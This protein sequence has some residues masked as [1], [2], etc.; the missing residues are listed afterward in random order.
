MAVNRQPL[1]KNMIKRILLTISFLTWLQTV[2]LCFAGCDY[3]PIGSTSVSQS[4]RIGVFI[5]EI[6]VTPTS[7]QWNGN[8]VTIK[9]AW[10]EQALVRQC[11]RKH[12]NEKLCFL[13]F[14]LKVNGKPEIGRCAGDKATLVFIGPDLLRCGQYVGAVGM[15]RLLCYRTP[16]SSGPIQRLVWLPSDQIPP[17]IE[18]RAATYQRDKEGAKKVPTN[19]V[20]SFNLAD[21]NLHTE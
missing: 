6:P 2:P 21:V 8:L 14:T 20:L 13:C 9:E 7:F 5:S 15:R 17:K 18:L 16:N 10:L 1:S 4:K 12:K 3:E 19:I 11:D